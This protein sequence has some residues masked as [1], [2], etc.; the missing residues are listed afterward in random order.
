MAIVS[1][2]TA[3]AKSIQ[4]NCT[5]PITGGYTGRAILIPVG[6]PTIAITQSSSNPRIVEAI[7]KADSQVDMANI[8]GVSNLYITPF[9]NSNK[10]SNGDNGVITF[11]KTISFHLPQRGAGIAKDI[12]EPLAKSALGYL[13]IAE[14]KDKVGD[15]SFEVI[16]LLQGLKVNADGVAQDEATSNGDTIITMSCVETW[17][18]ETFFDTDYAT[19]K[20][21]FDE[22]YALAI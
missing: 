5:N 1:C 21:A 20:S 15:G 14:K 7:E 3:V 22:L 12:V 11:T 10:A 8:I 17:F 19:T 16:G 6:E 13:C 18:E 2:A 4:P 9:E